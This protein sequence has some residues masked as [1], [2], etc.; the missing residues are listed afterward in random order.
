M[1]NWTAQTD[2]FPNG[3][4]YLY[5]QTG[6]LVQAHNRYWDMDTVYAKANGGPYDFIIDQI[7]HGSVPTDASFWIDLFTNSKSG[8]GLTVYEQDWLFNEFYQYV[9]PMLENVYL[10]KEWL[11]QMG[12][13]ARQ[14][15]LNV[16]YC[17]PYIRHLLQ[18][19]EIDIVTQARAS[20]DYVVSPYEG[21]DNWRIGGQTVLLEALGLASSKDGFWSTEYQ[22]GNPYG[23]DRYEPYS[24]LHSVVATL[25]SGPVA[26]A[27]GIGYSNVSLVLKSCRQ[28]GRLLQPDEPARMIDEVFLNQ[29]FSDVGP[30]GEVWF[31]SSYLNDLQYGY[32]FVA[33]LSSDYNLNIYSLLSDSFHLYHSIDK[34]P[35]PLDIDLHGPSEPDLTILQCGQS[36]FQLYLLAPILSNGWTFFGEVSKWVSVSSC[37]FTSMEV[38]VY[39]ITV[40]AIG[41]SNEV[42]TV[43]FMDPLDSY[44]EV[45]CEIDSKGTVFISSSGSCSSA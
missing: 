30:D 36:D 33:D 23:E 5:N 14:N 43:A 11:L 15:H 7:N 44:F 9:S 35:L 32:V 12:Y 6:W 4:D 42:V 3:L 24:S 21:V 2:I 37:R 19:L 8:W 26:I 13:G 31:A 16:Q 28:D 10:A 39:G 38:H 45:S 34:N 22:S 17:M 27:D 29:A 25:S 1:T 20:D 40:K 18:S 41:A